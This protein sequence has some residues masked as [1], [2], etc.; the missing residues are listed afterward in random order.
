MI[1]SGDNGDTITLNKRDR[2]GVI[3][4]VLPQATEILVNDLVIGVVPV[5]TEFFPGQ[6][7]SIDPANQMFDVRFDD[8]HDANYEVVHSVS[9]CEIRLIPRE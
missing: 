5:G 8:G 1:I 2:T 6:V 3:F 4:D 9:L 7:I